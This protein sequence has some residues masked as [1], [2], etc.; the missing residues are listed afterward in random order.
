MLSGFFGA[1]RRQYS[2]GA[3]G[4]VADIREAPGEVADVIDQTERLLDHDDAGIIAWLV[5]GRDI[6]RDP[7]AAA[8]Q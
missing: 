2:A 5:R 1:P 4:I 8:L 3:T 6:G 7:A